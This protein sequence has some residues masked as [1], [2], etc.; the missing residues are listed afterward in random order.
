[1]HGCQ[2][3]GCEHDYTHCEITNTFTPIDVVGLCC[4]CEHKYLYQGT[5]KYLS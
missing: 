3:C 4:A 5:D 2:N 1:M